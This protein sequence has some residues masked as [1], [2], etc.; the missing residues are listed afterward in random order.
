MYLFYFVVGFFLVYLFYFSYDLPA[1]DQMKPR[2]F[3]VFHGY[4]T[5]IDLFK[6]FY[7]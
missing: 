6:T 4:V 7:F 2:L 5:K 1:Y 3:H